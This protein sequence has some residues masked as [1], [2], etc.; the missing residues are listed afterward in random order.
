MTFAQF[1]KNKDK[2]KDK[3]KINGREKAQANLSVFIVISGLNTDCEANLHHFHRFRRIFVMI[4]RLH[5]PAEY[6]NMTK[7]F[8][9][10]KLHFLPYPKY[11]PE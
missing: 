6:A 11:N 9:L 5:F 2:D 7:R 4:F 1:S 10:F 3:G 8:P